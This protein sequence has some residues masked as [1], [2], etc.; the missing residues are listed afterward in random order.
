MRKEKSTRFCQ[1]VVTHKPRSIC[2]CIEVSTTIWKSD[3]SACILIFK[4]S[5]V[6]IDP[7]IIHVK[8]TSKLKNKTLFNYVNVI[9]YRN[10]NKRCL[11]TNT[12]PTLPS[13]PTRVTRYVKYIVRWLKSIRLKWLNE[14][15][16]SSKN[17]PWFKYI[18]S[19]YESISEM[20]H[21]TMI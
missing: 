7:V 5:F 3:A 2:P 21:G 16:M 13:T 4:Y 11:S 9:Y 19:I 18:T 17:S 6:P 10:L 15:Y 8:S 12:N 20:G 14:H 1:L